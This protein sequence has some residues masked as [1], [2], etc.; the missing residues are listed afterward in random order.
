[1]VENLFVETGDQNLVSD[2]VFKRVGLR[3]DHAQRRLR[4]VLTTTGLL[5]GA[6]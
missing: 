6:V 5:L 3:H 2:A 4:P 1:M